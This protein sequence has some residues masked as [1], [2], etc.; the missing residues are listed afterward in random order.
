MRRYNVPLPGAFS[1]FFSVAA[2]CDPPDVAVAVRPPYREVARRG[3]RALPREGR[4]LLRPH[5]E[6]GA[7]EGRWAQQVAPLPARG[8]PVGN[9]IETDTRFLQKLDRN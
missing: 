9:C 5:G 3:R 4:N 6:R 1:V 7:G 2:S 8:E